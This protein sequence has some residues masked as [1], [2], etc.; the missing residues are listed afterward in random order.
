MW[1]G[2]Q[3]EFLTPPASYPGQSSCCGVVVG[4]SCDGVCC[5]VLVVRVIILATY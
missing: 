5:V 3:S 2:E 1:Q 4:F